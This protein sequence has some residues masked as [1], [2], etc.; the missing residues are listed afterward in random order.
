VVENAL[1]GQCDRLKERSL[2]IDLF[3]RD[4]AYNTG[5]DSIVRVTATDVR[6]RLLQYYLE[7]DR[8]TDFRIELPSGSYIPEIHRAAAPVNGDAAPLA[9]APEVLPVP[10]WRRYQW[11]AAAAAALLLGVGFVAGLL[12]SRRTVPVAA[13]QSRA[14][15]LGFYSD[16]LGP[17][18]SDSKRGTQI[19]LS[20]PRVLLYTGSNNPDRAN[21]PGDV[22][23]RVPT[24]VE[25]LLN[26]TANDTQASFKYHFLSMAADDY[27]G[28]GEAISAFHVG[29]LLQSLGRTPQLTQAR[30]LNWE[31]ARNEHL[32]LLGAPH[33]S[34][35]TQESLNKSDF[36]MS[37]DAIL[38][39][40]PAAGERA[41]YPRVANGRILE[42]YGLLWMA[43]S[44]SG[45]RLL[46]MAGL[47]S[48]GTAG[49][50]GF[51]SDPERMR[52]VYEK[53]KAAV[54]GRSIPANW[55][56]LLKIEARQNVPVD[57]SFVAMRVDGAEAK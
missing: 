8:Q 25:R 9:G 20:N 34:A 6:K 51:F 26:P 45:S 15:D 18:L 10:A 14:Q 17:I 40:H 57:V 42:D 39:A 53:L 41:S 49:V 37:H 3:G 19:V 55:Q 47:T 21:W 13:R 33:M 52:P 5:D 46:L 27:T 30:F 1:D 12:L 56:V 28:M 35:W 48:T 16:L 24:D 22:D 11:H 54:K 43:E 29:N 38:N 32:L 50:G 36:T 7:P 23:V 4:A 44:P 2:G 31:A